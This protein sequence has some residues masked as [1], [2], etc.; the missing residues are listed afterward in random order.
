MTFCSASL[1]ALLILV[2]GIFIF[3]KPTKAE[4]KKFEKEEINIMKGIKKSIDSKNILNPG[5]II[6]Y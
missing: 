4:L 3:K 2:L 1:I 6:D 5:K